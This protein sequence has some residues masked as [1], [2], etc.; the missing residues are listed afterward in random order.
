MGLKEEYEDSVKEIKTDEYAMSLGEIA[1]MYKEGDLTIF[2]AYQRYFRWNENQ[3]SSFIESII[4]GIPTPS[5]FVSSDENSNWDVIDG[6]QRISTILEF[7]GI[8]K[9]SDS[10]EYYEPSRL[11]STKF[12]PSL[13]GK[14]WDKSENNIGPNFRRL[15]KRRKMGIIIID[16]S[17]NSDIKYEL[18][19]RLNTNGEPLSIQEIRNV[20]I[21]MTNDYLFKSINNIIT[22]EPFINILNMSDKKIKKQEDKDWVSEFFVSLFITADEIDTSLDIGSMIT[23]KLVDIAKGLSKDEIDMLLS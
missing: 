6:L 8:L 21:L 3:K 2:P 5:I 19:R 1:N 13:K 15:I 10:E 12:L 11:L 16:S 23:S 4:L 17:S 7:M 9:K 14:Y 18:F 20:S 22:Y